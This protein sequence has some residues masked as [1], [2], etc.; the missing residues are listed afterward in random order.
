MSRPTRCVPNSVR[1][2][3]TIGE[4][5]TVAH[6]YPTTDISGQL[7]VLGSGTS[8]GVPAVGCGCPVCQSSQSAESADPLQRDLGTASRATC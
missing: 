4:V 6:P 8:V 5:T 1:P 2:E 3:R 7:V